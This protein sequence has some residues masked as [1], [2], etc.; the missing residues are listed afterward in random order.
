MRQ[1]SA[2]AIAWF[3]LVILSAVY[4]PK[5][6][7]PVHVHDAGKFIVLDVVPTYS[8]LL[9]QVSGRAGEFALVVIVMLTCKVGLHA[10]IESHTCTLNIA[11]VAI[12]GIP[13]IAPL[14]ARLN[15]LGKLPEINENV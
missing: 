2:S 9:T 4:G 6:P 15:P 5:L 10:P 8:R 7:T 1:V 12:E 11:V 3:R 14:G 13:V